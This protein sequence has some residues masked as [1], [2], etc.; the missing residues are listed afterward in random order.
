LGRLKALSADNWLIVAVRDGTEAKLG[1]HMAKDA[2]HENGKNHEFW[3]FILLTVV[4]APVMSV[5]V[6]G[7]YGFLIWMYQLLAGPPGS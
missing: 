1:G 6:V 3:A 4:V 7:G 2:A 5:V